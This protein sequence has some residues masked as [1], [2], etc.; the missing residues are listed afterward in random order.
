MMRGAT[1]AGPTLRTLRPRSPISGLYRFT[2]MAAVFSAFLFSPALL[3]VLGINYAGQGGNPLE[4]I[5]VATVLG[6]VA[7]GLSVLVTGKMRFIG[8]SP[9]T[10]FSLI[11]LIAFATVQLLILGRPASGLLVT[12]LTPILLLYLVTTIPADLFRFLRC[13]IMVLLIANSFTGLA[14]FVFGIKLLPH[15]A[16]AIEIRGDGRALGLVGHPLTAA[17]LAG[18]ALVHLVVS[19]AMAGFRRMALPEIALHA[20]ALLAFGGRLALLATLSILIVFVLCDRAALSRLPARQRVLMRATLVLGVVAGVLAA[21]ASGLADQVLTRFAEDGGSTATRWAALKLAFHL[22]PDALFF[23]LAPGPRADMLVAFDT[24][25]GIEITWIGWLVDYGLFIALALLAV[26]VLIL[27]ACLRGGTRVHAYM[28]AYFLI[29][30]SGAQGL[31]A[32]SLLLAW[33]VVLL[34]TLRPQPDHRSALRSAAMSGSRPGPAPRAQGAPAIAPHR[35]G[36]TAHGQALRHRRAERR[37][38]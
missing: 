37:G 15:V 31:G 33:L 14:E 20:L 18:I 23:G 4:K 12:F 32:K 34:L 5:H 19:G 8:L 13:A 30:I 27:R 11:A 22:P 38:H 25:Y 16:G 6:L 35:Q 29:C 21:S 36:A 9:R 7:L 10:F 26:L 28:T 2:L 3:Y 1:A 17:F 24:P